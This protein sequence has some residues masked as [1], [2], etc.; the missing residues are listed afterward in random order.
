MKQ[1]D[2]RV[3]LNDDY[4]VLSVKGVRL[5]YGYEVTEGGGDDE[6][7][8]GGWC[9]EAT[10]GDKHIVLTQADI[11]AETQWECGENL[12]RGIATLIGRGE[13]VPSAIGSAIPDDPNAMYFRDENG[14]V[15][16]ARRVL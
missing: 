14:K 7:V 3:M 15:K 11:G 6:D 12:L 13:L 9:F 2:W 16:T 4:A 10:I 5:Y 8:P 1:R